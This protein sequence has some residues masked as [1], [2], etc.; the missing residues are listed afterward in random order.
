MY[1]PRD[2]AFS[3]VKQQ[4]F[5]ETRVK[6]G[7]DAFVTALQT[8]LI[9]QR[10]GFPDFRAIDSLFDED[11]KL[12]PSKGRGLLTNTLLRLIKAIYDAIDFFQFEIPE[13]MDSKHYT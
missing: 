8:R 13:T 7:L 12:P 4:S 1:V 6:A 10:L 3:E 5:E 2:E 9:N 11:L